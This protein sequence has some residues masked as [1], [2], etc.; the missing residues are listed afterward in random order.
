ML[1]LPGTM[2][3]EKYSPFLLVLSVYLC[4]V[5]VPTHSTSAPAIGFPSTSLQTPFTLPVVCENASGADSPTTSTSKTRRMK[6]FFMIEP[7]GKNCKF[8]NQLPKN[9]CRFPVILSEG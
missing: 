2:P 6:Y 5:S 9:D 3:S 8:S 7:P 1:Y 4:P